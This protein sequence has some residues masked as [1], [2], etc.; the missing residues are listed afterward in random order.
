[1][2]DT[3]TLVQGTDEW[4][5]ARLGKVSASRIADMLATTKSGWGASRT[6]YMMELVCERMTGVPTEGFKSA[7][8]L[9][10]TEMEPVAR[11]RYAFMYDIEVQQVGWVPHPRIA[12]AG[13]SPDGYVGADGLIEI[14]CPLVAT[15]VET[16]LGGSLPGKYYKQCQFQLACTGRAW[17]DWISFNDKLPPE[18]VMFKRRVMR[19]DK[20]VDEIEKGVLA[21]LAEL[22]EVLE[23]LKA[24]Q[25]SAL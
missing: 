23:K 19:D 15:H 9:N 24:L 12:E 4:R 7:A 16:L 17:I 6:N 25:C 5:Q 14:K 1:M 21:F 2:L 13:C 20:V 22:H 8:M 3:T 11:A 18:L 10:G